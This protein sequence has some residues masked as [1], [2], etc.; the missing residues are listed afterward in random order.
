[1]L[2][3][4]MHSRIGRRRQDVRPWMGGCGAA[5]DGRMPPAARI[6]GFLRASRRLIAGHDARP[7]PAVE[8]RGGMEAAAAQP[9]SRTMRGR[10]VTFRGNRG[11]VWGRRPQRRRANAQAH[12]PRRPVRC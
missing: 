2:V 9:H 8:R 5:M 7:L 10:A 3:E 6:G 4:E 1:V 11:A 12:L